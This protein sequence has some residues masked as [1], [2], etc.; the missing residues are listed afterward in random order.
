MRALGSFTV[1]PRLPEQLAA[2]GP[3]AMNLRWSWDERTQDLFR[4]VDP[5]AWEATG[6]DPIRLLGLVEQSRLEE[7]ARDR[8]FLSFLAE[9]EDDLNRYLAAERWFQGRPSPLR[10]VAYFSPEFGIA[11]ALPQYSGG[12]GVLAGDHLKSANGLGLPLVG[13]GLFYH[14]GYFRQELDADGWQQERYVELDPFAMALTPMDGVTI[15]VD[16]AGSPLSARVWRAQVGRIRLFLLDSDVD[17]N[18]QAGRSVTDRLYGGDTEH[19][20]RQEILL[21][22]GGVRALGALDC[23]PQV[24]HTNEGHAGFLGLERIRRAITEDGLSFDE[25]VEA[26]RAGTVFTTHTPVPAGIDRFGRPL[27]E[28]YFGSWAADCGIHFDQLMALGQAPGESSDTPFNMAVMG[29]RLAGFANGVSALHGRV[30]REIFSSVWPGLPTQDLPIGSITNGVHAR[31][32]VSA[33]MNDLFDRYVLPEWHAA[34]ADRWARIDDVGDD[35]L[36]RARQQARERLVAFVRR[37]LRDTAAARGESELET[38]WCDDAFDPTALTIGFARRFAPYKRATLLLSDP[39]RL[40]ALLLDADR[41]VQFL[42]AGKAHPADNPGKEMI[43]Q[44][45]RFARQNHLR[46]RIAFLEDYDMAVARL[47]YQGCDVWLNTPRRP[48]EACGT[49]GEKAALNGALNCSILDGW[50]DEMFD[51][52]NGWAIPSA[53]HA[54]TERRDALEGAGLFH[55]LENQIV[56]LYYDRSPGRPPARW[57]ARVRHSLRT[58]GPRVPAS[59]MVRDYAESLYEP[60]AAHV[61]RMAADQ[62]GPARD[63]AQ[64]KRQ[65]AAHWAGVAARVE[66]DQSGSDLGEERTVR[67]QVSLG[68]LSPNDVSVELLHGPVGPTGE[69]TDTEVVHM[70]P[71]GEAAPAAGSRPGSGASVAYEG[72]FA[73]DRAGRYGFTVRVVPAH[74]ELLSYTDLGCIT[75]AD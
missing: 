46:H 74:P 71:A 51:G 17:A 52:R 66:P 37:R 49:S 29:L 4:W 69:L 73:C 53:E 75:W 3:L 10:S 58:L 11:E 40:S 24:F 19:R 41:P 12:L 48:L 15:T 21:G 26:V 55:L 1:R 63:L 16:L 44:V 34:G 57:L 27:M 23:W 18:D 59:R 35:V 6:H 45:V 2:L 43:R 13:V 42:F 47:M 32:W 5:D 54:E 22:V 31:T 39:D 70:T 68:Q 25:A 56:P 30:S 33:E 64:W 14:Q 61:D 62:W 72:R 20:L 28:K 50:W 38:A 9:V 8:T 7:V 65:T 60:A 67:A 36:W